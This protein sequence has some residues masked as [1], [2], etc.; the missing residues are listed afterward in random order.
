MYGGPV[1][2]TV[3]YNLSGGIDTVTI[4][5][6]AGYD[7]LLINKNQQSFTIKDQNGKVLFQA[8]TGRTIITITGIE[9]TKVFGDKGETLWEYRADVNQDGVLDIKDAILSMQ[10]LAG[11]TPAQPVSKDADIDGDRRIG[12]AEAIYVLQKVAGL[13]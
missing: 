11:V 7:T 12:L 1:N 5:G 6:G 13:R 10:V 4:N 2:D 8:G 3:T 9:Y